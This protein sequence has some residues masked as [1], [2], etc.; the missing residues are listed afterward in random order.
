MMCGE[1]KRGE[2]KGEKAGSLY[3]NALLTFLIFLHSPLSHTLTS[4]PSPHAFVCCVG[5]QPSP[6]LPLF[7]NTSIAT[8][9]AIRGLLLLLLPLLLILLLQSTPVSGANPYGVLGVNRDAT[10]ADIRKAY[11]QLALK[12]YAHPLYSLLSCIHYSY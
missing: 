6:S 3:L 4:T 1:R 5:Q 10:V 2:S 7:F 9:M 11:K 8:Q 12:W